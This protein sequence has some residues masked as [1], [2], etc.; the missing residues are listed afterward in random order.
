MYLELEKGSWVLG[1]LKL[2]LQ[3]MHL[4]AEPPSDFT[5]AQGPS[6]IFLF[7][8]LSWLFSQNI[9]LQDFSLVFFVKSTNSYHYE[10]ASNNWAHGADSRRDEHMCTSRNTHRLLQ[11]WQ[12]ASLYESQGQVSTSHGARNPLSQTLGRGQ[13]MWS[14]LS[15]QPPGREG[16]LGA[17][18]WGEAGVQEQERWQMQSVG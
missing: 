3:I 9:I 5:R 6:Y 18:G 14:L 15:L 1:V 16:S 10:D 7:I 12:P 8:N 2:C 11:C 4:L 13:Q 17:A